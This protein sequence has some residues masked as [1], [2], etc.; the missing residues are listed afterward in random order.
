M[1]HLVLIKVYRKPGIFT[2]KFI[3]LLK[4][5]AYFLIFLVLWSSCN[6]SSGEK[7]LHE[8]SLAYYPPTPEKIDQAEFRQYYRLISEFFEKT[9]L[10]TNFNGAILVAKGGN[11]IYEKYRGF[12]N[13]QQRDSI[14]DST[15]FHIASTSKTFTSIA[16]LKLVQQKKLSLDDSLTHFFPGF[17]YPGITIRMLLNHRSGLPNYIYFMD[18]ADWDKSN[19]VT[20][21]DVLNYLYNSQP[22]RSFPPDTHFSY[23]NTNFVMLALIIEKISGIPFPEYMQQNIFDPLQMTHTHIFRLADSLTATPSFDAGGG[24]WKNDFLEATY[25]DKNV[26]T[27]PRDLLKWDQALYDTSF[28][29]AASLDSAFKPYSLEWNTLHNYGLGF[30]LKLYPNG[31]KVVYH[32]GRWHGFNAAFARLMDEKIVIIILGNRFT[33]SIYDVANSS[34][35]LFGDYK[36]GN[37]KEED[38]NEND[39]PVRKSTKVHKSKKTV[40]RT[41]HKKVRRR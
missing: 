20:N 18:N 41:I 21:Q 17:P 15:Q 40:H 19:Y 26:Y 30:R 37:E 7:T 34:Y 36:Q 25:G 6:I 32:F 12:A 29:S 16:I 38:D 28:I 27:T 11:I 9:L 35:H 13:L 33:R 14:T 4:N 10:R 22:R 39:N 8:D 5:S 2:L 31:K 23:S 3:I 1:A 24:L